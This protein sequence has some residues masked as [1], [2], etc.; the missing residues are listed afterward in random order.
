MACRFFSGLN[1]S[2]FMAKKFDADKSVYDNKCPILYTVEI[3]SSKWKIPILW[4][5]TESENNT[6]RYRELQRK[7]T[8]ITETMLTKCL[9][10][11]EQAKIVN[12]QQYNTI[13]P[14]VEYSLTKRGKSLI[15]V[16]NLMSNWG[17]T[18]MKLD[19]VL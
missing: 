15:P 16:L 18:Q 9:K 4:Y 10:E 13:P 11:L 14:I 12:R 6:L 17:E 7:V 2:D 1:W 5:L 3:F 8:G 19:G